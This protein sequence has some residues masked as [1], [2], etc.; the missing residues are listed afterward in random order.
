[1]KPVDFFN[2][3]LESREKA[4]VFHWMIKSNEIHLTMEYYYT[5]IIELLDTLIECYQG[6]YEILEGYGLMNE[7][8]ETDPLTY[9][10]DY[11]EYIE[12][13][14]KVI[15]ETDTFLHNTIDEIIALTYKTIFKLKYLK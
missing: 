1:M 5:N 3:V 9:F 4:Q 8:K 15:K 13:N 14:K 11:I 6:K 10:K 2:K 12:L 7:N